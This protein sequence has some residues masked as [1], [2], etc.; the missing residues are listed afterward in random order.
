M[1]ALNRHLNSKRDELIATAIKATDYANAHPDNE[2]A[3]QV[4]NACSDAAQAG[5]LLA[6]QARYNR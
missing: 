6:D 3:Q 5:R 2:Q 1:R 4:A